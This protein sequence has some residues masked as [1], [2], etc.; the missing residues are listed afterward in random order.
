MRYKVL[1]WVLIVIILCLMC[2]LLGFYHGYKLANE[3]RDKLNELSMQSVQLVDYK[4][5]KDYSIFEVNVTAYSPSPHITQGDPFMMASGRRVRIQ[6]L[7][8]LKYVALSRDL[9]KKYNLKFGDKVYIGFEFQDL[10]NAKVKNTIDI[11]MRNLTLARQFGRQRRNIVI[12][13]P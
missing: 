2:Y 11:F 5:K 8:E 4:D 12:I 10:M 1:Y 3:Y 7:W 13:K 9:V 6:D